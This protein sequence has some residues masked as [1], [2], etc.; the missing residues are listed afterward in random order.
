MV[1]A[2]DGALSLD[3]T[4]RKPGRGVY[5]C[6]NLACMKKALKQKQIERQLEVSMTSEVAAGLEKLMAELPQEG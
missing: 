3:L 4:G 5:L 1:R 6:R 2:P